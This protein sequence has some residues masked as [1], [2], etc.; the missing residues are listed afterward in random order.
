MT[1]EDERKLY[2]A[3]LPDAV[4][5]DSLR[6]LFVGA[7][8]QVDDVS[9]PRDRVT[10]RPRGFAFV[11]VSSADQAGAA[12]QQL[13]GMLFGGRSITV[14]AFSREPPAPGAAPRP[15]F[16]GRSSFGGSSGGYGGGGGGGYG[17]GAPN[18]GAPGGGYGGGGAPGGGYG[19]GSPG[20]YAP[21]PPGTGFAPRPGGPGGPGG[22]F[23]DAADRTLHVRNLP[24]DC[25]EADVG[26]A[27]STLG[28]PAPEEVRLPKDAMT[29]RARG[30]AFVRFTNAE[31]AQKAMQLTNGEAMIG[32]RRCGLSFANNKPGEG[33]PGGPR[34]PFGGPGG[35]RPRGPDAAD[36][37]LATQGGG[38]R[39][40]PRV[41]REDEESPAA[42]KKPIPRKPDE[43][44]GGGRPKPRARGG[45]NRIDY[46]DDD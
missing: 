41:L 10:G 43:G 37:W 33:G 3:G 42:K 12:R 28:A 22:R 46:N 39:V 5:E 17:G 11:T 26:G 1:T 31:D 32:G 15:G 45:A 18:G 36:V 21:R 23:Q 40:K 13:H 25:A 20:G 6:Q 2:V 35:P 30:F 24:Y 16:Q 19:G 8:V 14:R 38:E 44:R 7:G 9:I 27:F 34:P 4:T 29:G